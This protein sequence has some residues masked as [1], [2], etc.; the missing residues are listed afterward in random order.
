MGPRASLDGSG[1]S[2]PVYL[3]LIC[4]IGCLVYGCCVI[5][6]PVLWNSGLLLQVK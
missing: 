2:R 1:K 6:L 5:S 4:F 3:L